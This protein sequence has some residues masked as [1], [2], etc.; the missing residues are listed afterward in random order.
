M[1]FRIAIIEFPGSNCERETSLAVKRAGMQPIPFLWNAQHDALKDFDGYILVGGFSYEDRVRAGLIASLEPL[2]D[3]LKTQSQQGK[4]ILGICNGAQ[5]LV[6]SG[7]VPGF[8]DY[9]LMAALTD[10]K[11]IDAEGKVLGT[12]YYNEWVYMK[13]SHHT[14]SSAFISTTHA[15]KILHIPVAHGEGRFILSAQMLNYLDKKGN[16]S[17]HY[18]EAGGKIEESFPTNP[19]G[20]IHNLAAISNIAGNVMAMMPHPERT[21]NGDAVFQAMHEY[22]EKNSKHTPHAMICA[23]FS[24]ENFNPVKIEAADLHFII[25]S[26]V[27]D[28]TAVSLSHALKQHY[29]QAH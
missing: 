15:N 11:R 14:Q 23:P 3:I 1:S 29:P 2:I 24:A 25:D 6:E 27:T 16:A 22:L 17:Y 13:A 8:K 9:P 19:N 26:I 20:A 12:G 4:P 28:N 18:C 21:L 5:I 7:L 10:N